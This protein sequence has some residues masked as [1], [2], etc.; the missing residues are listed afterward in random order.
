[1]LRGRP[2]VVHGDGCVP[3]TVT[4]SADLAVG[5]VGLLGNPA[6][7]GQSFH[8]TGDEVLT[9]DQI[10]RLVGA[11]VG[12]LPE[13]VHLASEDIAAL[14]PQRAGSLLGDKAHAMVFDNG[15]IKAAVPRFQQRIPFA[16]GIRRTVAWFRA[17][18]RRMVV[19]AEVEAEIERLLAARAALRD[20]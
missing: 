6:A 20:S 18:P 12:A 19:S 15:K 13:L 3:W 2:V 17:D 16:E 14:L 11:A 10:H 5:L 4:H 8:I 7:A 1:M 9:W